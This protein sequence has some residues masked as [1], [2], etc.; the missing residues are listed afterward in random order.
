MKSTIIKDMIQSVFSNIETHVI[1]E[2]LKAKESIFV[3]QYFLTNKN[4][5]EVLERKALEMVD[6]KILLEKNNLNKKLATGQNKTTMNIKN[7]LYYNKTDSILHHKFC[8]IDRL[9]VI[10]GSYNWSNTAEIKNFENILIINDQLV[11]MKYYEEFQK[12]IFSTNKAIE[13]DL[14]QTTPWK[15]TEEVDKVVIT[16]PNFLKGD[17]VNKLRLDNTELN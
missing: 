1:N 4:I 5:I 3:C 8:V 7:R 9:T 13:G 10:T 15:R 6:V 11:A 12:L 2:L 14:E 17:P 16:L